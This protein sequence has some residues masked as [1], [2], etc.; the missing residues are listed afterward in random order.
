MPNTYFRKSIKPVSPRAI[1]GVSWAGTSSPT[2]TRTDAGVGM[3]ANAGV[4]T[5]VVVNDFDTAEIYKNI[6]EVSDVLGNV[7]IRVPKFWIE[8]TAAGAARTWRISPHPF[9]TSYLPKCFTG[10]DY[11]DVGKY[12]ANL[13]S[14]GTKLESKSGTYPLISKNIVQFRTYAQANGVGYQ[15]LDIHVVD[16]L[17]VLFIIEFATLN[18]QSIMYG[19]ASG[20]Y[21]AAD[22]ATATEAGANRIVVTNAVAANFVVG[23]AISCGTSLG[24][25]Q[26][27]YGRTITSISVV[28][29][30]NKALNFDGAAVDI[31]TGNIVYSTGWKSGF[32]SGITAKSG[33]LTSNSTGKYPC[34]YRGIENPFGSVYQFVDGVNINEYQAWVCPTPSSYASNLFANPYEQ[35]SYVNIN[36]DNYVVAMG[37][38]TS[39]P[40]ANFPTNV[41]GG[42]SSTYYSDY[43]YK[44]TGQRIAIFGGAWNNGSSAGLFAWDLDDASSY[45]HVSL[46]GRLLKRPL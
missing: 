44:N 5:N 17:Q 40:Y 27:F 19:F 45:T 6:T 28:D 38:D 1:Y 8:K 23:Q 43:Y 41:T 14:G 3:V 32:S 33:S 7:F 20:R 16:L 22:T 37:F 39:C 9:G 31:A 35:L 42:N 29:A 26:K 36:A 21:N 34:M 12:N 25:N 2:L 46:G 24:G 13:D 10:V 15:Q 4:D 18:S 30:S 11:V